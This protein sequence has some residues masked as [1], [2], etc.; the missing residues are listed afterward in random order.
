M[1][2]RTNMDSPRVQRDLPYRNAL[3]YKTPQ[4]IAAMAQAQAPGVSRN[5]PLSSILDHR[6][7]LLPPP[8]TTTLPPHTIT[9]SRGAIVYAINVG[10]SS[11]PTPGSVSVVVA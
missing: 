7:W 8:P 3:Q 9:L 11:N 2:D 6:Q 10:P 4:T 5:T 1:W